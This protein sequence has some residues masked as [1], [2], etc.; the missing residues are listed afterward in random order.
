[1]KL[2]LHN[3]TNAYPIVECLKQHKIDYLA[4]V[5]SK[6]IN[7]LD[8]G[9]V[10]VALVPSANLIT[11]EDLLPLLTVP[12][13]A[14]KNKVASVL[15]F[16]SKPLKEVKSIYA[17]TDSQTS[18]QL[19]K[20]LARYS[21][22]IDFSWAKDINSA[23]AVLLIG[24]KAMLEDKS[25]YI[26]VLDLG[27]QWFNYSGLSFVWA[28]W[29]TKQKEKVNEIENELSKIVKIDKK[30]MDSAMDRAV[31]DG[32]FSRDELEKYYRYNIKFNL[33]KNELKGL[34]KFL[35]SPNPLLKEGAIN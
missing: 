31:N 10:D 25:S 3:Y 26:E 19:C 18:V 20:L 35:T 9:Q 6:I 13:I 30:I 4:D 14:S 8:S 22:K 34:E 24:D 21:W 7:L 29:V 1:M 27:E 32:K 28:L 11:R 23:E 17:D 2:A 16:C 12:G 15:L 5:P 33:G